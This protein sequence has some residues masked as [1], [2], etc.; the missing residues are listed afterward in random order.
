MKPMYGQR[1][2]AIYAGVLTLLVV[3][4]LLSGFVGAPQRATF[5]A[6]TVHRI[7]VV[8]PD[9]TLRMVIS[10]QARFPGLIVRGKH[11]AHDRPT[12]G[13]LFYN[14]EGTENGGLIFGGYTDKNGKVKSW[15]HL[16]FDQYM[17]DQVFTIDAS[18][19]DGKR[20][21]G[22]ELIDRPTYPIT[23]IV[24]LMQRM[25]GMSDVQR[26]AALHAFQASHPSPSK[27]LVMARAPDGGVSLGL[28]DRRGHPRIV[29]EVAADGTPSIRMLDANGTVVSALRPSKP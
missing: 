27:R 7:D 12:A 16:S 21:A 9:G 2:L 17:Q 8:E 23:E 11:Y 20:T 1:L 13:M 19:V 10:D 15:G 3:A 6:L 5:D 24:A 18:D 26:E 28:N 25:R 22:L 4:A 29:L 14:N